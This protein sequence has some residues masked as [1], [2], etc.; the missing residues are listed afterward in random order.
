MWVCVC[1]FES[2]LKQR[3]SDEVKVSREDDGSEG[4][5]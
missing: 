1:V 5:Q 3:G 2:G 4:L